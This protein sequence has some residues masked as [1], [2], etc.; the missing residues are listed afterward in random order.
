M[1]DNPFSSYAFSQ[2]RTLFLPIPQ[3]LALFTVALPLITFA[4]TQGIWTL[5][6]HSKLEKQQLTI[7]LIAVIGFQFIYETV[8]AT[9]ALTF[10]LPPSSLK[11]GLDAKWQTFYA[12]KDAKSIRAIQDALN[13]CGFN[14][15]ADRAFPW[16]SQ[17]PSTCPSNYQRSQNCAGIWRKME[18]KNAGLL[19]FVVVVVFIVKV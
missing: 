10:I 13:C 15:L 14:T 16:G 12:A 1:T 5:I 2:I 4:S 17:Q 18:Q 6:Q 11:C 7:P 19:L 8:V 9:L 3:A